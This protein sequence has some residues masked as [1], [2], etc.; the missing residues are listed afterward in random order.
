MA[1]K[2]PHEHLKPEIFALVDKGYKPSEICSVYPGIPTATVY[3]WITQYKATKIDDSRKGNYDSRIS[4]E[5]APKPQPLKVVATQAELLSPVHCDSPREELRQVRLWLWKRLQKPRKED[6][7]AFQGINAY[8]RAIQ[9]EVGLTPDADD[10]EQLTDAER[11][12]R[13]AAIFDAARARRT[14]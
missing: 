4:P 1:R 9:I 10:D 13:A 11:S 14:G 5:L 12:E 3:A 8:L 6:A 7:I 2:S